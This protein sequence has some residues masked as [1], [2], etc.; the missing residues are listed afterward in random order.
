[1]NFRD[2]TIGKRIMA[3]FLVLV[4]LLTLAVF[5]SVTGVGRIVNNAS[6]VIS[7]NKL[8]GELAQKEVDH[9]NWINK[10]NAFLTDENVTNLDVQTD[11]KKCE[12]GKWLESEDR[13][14]AEKLVQ[15]LAPLLKKIDEP[16][17]KIHESA[18]AIQKLYKKIND[19]LP[20]F[21]ASKE[22]EHMKWTGAIDRLFLENLKQLNIEAD[23]AKCEFGKWLYSK[24][25]MELSNLDN[26]LGLLIK[27]I[28]VPHE[29]LHESAIV[30]QKLY[31]RQHPGLIETLLHRLDDHRRWGLILAEGILVGRDDLGIQLDETQCA[32]GKWLL[33]DEVK[34]YAITFPAFKAAMDEIAEPHTMLHETAVEVQEFLEAGAKAF[35]EEIYSDQAIPAMEAVAN[36]LE[37][38]ILAEKNLV[39]GHVEAKAHY[40]TV[41][42]PAMERTRVLMDK[43][44]KRV[45]VLLD[46]ANRANEVFAHET[47][48]A[49]A[50]FQK[51]LKQIRSQ[52]R[53]HIMTDTDMLKSARNIKTNIIVIGLIS[54]VLGI[55]MGGIIT[56]KII[57]L[58]FDLSSKVGQSSVEVSDAAMHV[59]DASQ[60]LAEG[61]SQQAASLEQTSASLEQI[62]SMNQTNADRAD[63][64]EILMQGNH[65][66]MDDANYIMKELNSSMEEI[67]SVSNEI[68]KIIQ[69]I[70]EIAFQTNLLALNAAV[71]AARAGEAGAGFAVVANEVR[72]LSMRAADA[73]SETSVLIGQAV[74]KV[75]KGSSLVEKTNTVFERVAASSDKITTLINQIASAIKEQSS[76]VQQIAD[77]V[78][79]IDKATQHNAASAEESASASEELTGQAEEMGKI[80]R[81]LGRLIGT[82]NNNVSKEEE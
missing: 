38:I 44:K 27:K 42:L 17:K 49:L 15:S 20:G 37:K 57:N 2:M 81:E 72:N 36:G 18:I 69:S 40:K 33:S 14:Q 28:K 24:E 55:I 4:F 60:S 52:A 65:E 3:G 43:I 71:E 62:S 68:S 64:S 9:L 13:K 74:D 1:M 61:A 7:G 31:R 16:H 56:R 34:N 66:I 39:K 19:K 73:A 67:S 51:L 29:K 77:S 35:A 70:D 21:L 82:N 47:L 54:I 80:A 76:G 79:E 26:E 22:L 63:Q 48:P 46:D 8:D 30:I 6:E 11:A 75:Q 58:L 50:R 41:T 5:L 78:A 12:F 23:P 25:A 45:D 32:F 10:V 53:N 59:S